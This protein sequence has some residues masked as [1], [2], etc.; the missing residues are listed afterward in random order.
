ML[1][2]SKYFEVQVASAEF[3]G[4][5]S[6]WIFIETEPGACVSDINCCWFSIELDCIIL[7]LFLLKT[8]NIGFSL[9]CFIMFHFSI[10]VIKVY[11]I[12]FKA[13]V[14]FHDRPSKFFFPMPQ[15]FKYKLWEWGLWVHTITWLPFIFLFF[16][17]SGIRIW[18]VAISLSFGCLNLYYIWY[19][20]Y[21][22]LTL[23]LFS[24]DKASDTSLPRKNYPHIAKWHC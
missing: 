15:P 9:N 6:C 21:C 16:R 1:Q 12:L 20:F 7:P 13:A 14:H 10:T 11:A 18:W 19:I 23:G 8:L 24:W 4:I 22:L 5:S 17:L 2:E 3:A